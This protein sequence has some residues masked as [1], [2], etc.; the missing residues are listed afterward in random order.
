MDRVG[1]GDLGGCHDMRH[2]EVALGAG[3]F[4]DK[5]ASSANLRAKLS[6]SAVEYT[7]TVLMP[8]SR[9]VRITRY[10]FS[11]LAI[12]IFFKHNKSIKN[13]DKIKNS[14]ALIHLNFLVLNFSF[15]FRRVY[16]GQKVGHT[17]PGWVFHQ[18]FTILP[19]TLA[20]DLGLKSFMASMMQTTLPGLISSPTFTK[21]GLPD[22][23]GGRRCRSSGFYGNKI[24]GL[25]LAAGF[26][27]AA[28]AA[29]A[30]A[31]A[32]ERRPERQ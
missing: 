16:E 1:I 26:G 27:A 21:M 3:L 24:I 25:G 10:Y 32:G 29:G 7:A 6:L 2:I 20:F 4:T 30:G 12:G 22:R 14:K 23:P 11:R 15:Y 28:A 17:P 31:G 5:T 9:Q 13:E 18:H 19:F 8:I